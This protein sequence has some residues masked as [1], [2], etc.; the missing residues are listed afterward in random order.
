MIMSFLKI[1]IPWQ[2]I[3]KVILWSVMTILF[4]VV[5]GGV[6]FLGYLGGYTDGAEDVR[7]ALVSHTEV[8]TADL[9]TLTQAPVSIAPTQAVVRV[10]VPKINWGGPEL[11]QEVN[12]KR[13]EY[14]VNPLTKADELCT[15]ASIRLNELMELGSLDN[16]EGF[17]N[18]TERRLDLKWIFEKYSVVAEF[19][20]MGG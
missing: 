19:L 12:K 20:A 5:F 4:I 9:V 8:K 1:N 6:Y 11:W 16:H 3:I 13:Q 2:E 18:M 15:I 10:V 17:S 14:G 7:N